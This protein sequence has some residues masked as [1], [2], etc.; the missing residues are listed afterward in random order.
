MANPVTVTMPLELTSG[1]LRAVRDHDTTKT[2]DRDEWH[3][4]LGWLLCAWD[5]L[6]AQRLPPG[7]VVE[8]PVEPTAALLRPFH[9]CPPEE[10][11]LAWQAMVAVARSK[12]PNVGAKLT[13]AAG[14]V[15]LVRDDAP[16]AADQPYGACRSGSA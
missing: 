6:V 8:V 11:E 5:V 4:R 10:L 1:M 3:R 7:D 2:E 9:E 12:T 13:A 14:G 15:R 16:S